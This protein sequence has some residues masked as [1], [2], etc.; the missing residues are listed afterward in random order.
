MPILHRENKMK[1]CKFCGISF[2]AKGTKITCS[3]ECSKKYNEELSK[4]QK[5]IC[6]F[7][8]S[9]FEVSGKSISNT[10]SFTCGFLFGRRKSLESQGKYK[11][12]K[13]VRLLTIQE[14][15]Y[16]KHK[17][18]ARRRPG[19][20]TK[21]TLQEFINFWQKD[22]TY[23]GDKIE[24][25]GLDRI[26]SDVGYIKGN[27]VPCCKHCNWMKNKNSPEFFLN[28]CKKVANHSSK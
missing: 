28:H 7:C 15:A 27:V 5:R 6:V 20:G 1:K 21:L 3:M 24:T 19:I 23:C 16:G 14:I 22:C 9:P 8:G 2:N 13:A 11:E 17:Q 4:I 12:A 18:E 25:I 26:N 10:C